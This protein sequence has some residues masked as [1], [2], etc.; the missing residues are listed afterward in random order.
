MQADVP[1]GASDRLRP[2]V[3]AAV[4]AP[5][6]LNA[7]IVRL[8]KLTADLGPGLAEFHINPVALIRDRTNALAHH[9][10]AM[11]ASGKRCEP[12]ERHILTGAPI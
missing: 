8:S 11:T 3:A 12:A 4:G 9:A 5:A 2:C 1:S 6:A 10:P 7:V